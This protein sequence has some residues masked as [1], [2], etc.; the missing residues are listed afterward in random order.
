MAALTI[1]DDT[2]TEVA[3]EIDGDRVRI[4]AGALEAATGWSLKPEGLCRGDVCVPVPDRDTMVEGSLIDLHAVAERLGQRVV[5][6]AALGA[7]AL[8]APSEARNGVRVGQRAA[9]VTLENVDGE[10]VALS[11][12]HGRKTLLVAFASW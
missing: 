4:D 7:V 12:F 1:L 6:D 11:S 8:S 5:S 9:D 2:E 3:G 10:G